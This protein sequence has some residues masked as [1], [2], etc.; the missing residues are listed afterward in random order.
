MTTSLIDGLGESIAD[1]SK[2]IY[3]Y[4]STSFEHFAGDR[5]FLEIEDFWRWQFMVSFRGRGVRNREGHE[6]CVGQGLFGDGNLTSS[7]LKW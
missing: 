4:F 5:R 1:Q 6:K 7:C 3:D 2:M